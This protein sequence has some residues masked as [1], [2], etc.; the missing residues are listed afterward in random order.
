MLGDSPIM[1]RI[2]LE[3]AS[4]LLTSYC[5]VTL[6]IRWMNFGVLGS[7]FVAYQTI[8]LITLMILLPW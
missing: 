5:V 4:L 6:M 7:Y 8:F 1:K 3:G 2:L